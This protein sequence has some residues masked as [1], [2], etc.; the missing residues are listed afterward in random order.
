[1]HVDVASLLCPWWGR[2]SL[3]GLRDG[4]RPGAS[5]RGT[6]R[7]DE[8]ATIERLIEINLSTL[9]P[10]SR[11]APRGQHPKHHGCVTAKFAV[12]RDLPADLRIGVF[13]NPKEFDA[14]I[15]FS[16]GKEMDDRTPDA[17]GMAIKL[18]D[19]PGPKLLEGHEG[20]TAHDFV[21]VDSEVFF[22]VG[23]KGY[24]EFNRDAVKAKN[25]GMRR[26]LFL[27]KYLLLNRKMLSDAKSFS[28]QTPSSPLASN[29]WSTTPYR[30]GGYAVKYMAA[31]VPSPPPNGAGVKTE[32][33][34]SEALVAQLA[35]GP[36]NFDFGVHIQSDAVNHPIEDAT[37]SWSKE[38]ARFVRLATIR[39][40]QQSVDPR[41]D[42]AERLVFSPWHALDEHRPLGA[43]NRARRD[44]Y[45][46]MAKRRHELNGVTP[47]GS[48]M[49]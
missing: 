38:G 18:L 47:A 28:D 40:G 6:S 39:I 26:A 36:A 4:K 24:P 46:K 25:G 32:N 19:V 30:L 43:I 23:L 11:P 31:A 27:A 34:L 35:A 16:N 48:S 21:L 14:L 15:R 44:V 12:E 45:A 3:A 49:P 20:E 29:Y 22:S 1:M 5:W 33:G 17:H 7:G 8:K 37:I 13:A 41:S 9:E 10:N 2:W 42:Q